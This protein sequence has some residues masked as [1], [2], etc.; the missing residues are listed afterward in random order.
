MYG[1]DEGNVHVS[2]FKTFFEHNSQGYSGAILS[3][4]AT[5]MCSYSAI[6]YV[7]M[8]IS[9]L[10]PSILREKLKFD[11][12]VISDYDELGRI[13]FQHLPTSFQTMKGI[14]ESVAAAMNAG[15]DMMMLPP[16]EGEK[17]IFI[18]F[19]SMKSALQNGV[20]TEARLNDAVARILS[21]KMA[22]GLVKDRNGN[23]NNNKK[24]IRKAIE[25]NEEL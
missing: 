4:V 20:I 7:P 25:E 1:A 16:F 24:G 14:N 18:H 15:I 8:A 2:S 19:D 10:L 9:T 11:G 13:I 6:N 3:E 23:N 12:F 21:V 5:V 22:L 17:N